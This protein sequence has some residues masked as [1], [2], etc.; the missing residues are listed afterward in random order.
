MQTTNRFGL[1]PRWLRDADTPPEL[2]AAASRADALVL[3]FVLGTV[4]GMLIGGGA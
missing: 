2:A 3:A 4:L 1:T